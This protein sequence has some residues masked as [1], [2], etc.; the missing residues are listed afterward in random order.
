[1]RSHSAEDYQT[2]N[3]P[4]PTK[5]GQNYLGFAK[6]SYEEILK[7]LATSDYILCVRFLWVRTFFLEDLTAWCFPVMDLV[8]CDW[9]LTVLA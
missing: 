7:T 3:N 5:A 6:N 9:E 2:K 8:I 1:V 4:A